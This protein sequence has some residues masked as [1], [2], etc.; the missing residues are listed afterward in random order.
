[1]SAAPIVRYLAELV[2]RKAKHPDREKAQRWL[3][4]QDEMI[5]RERAVAQKKAGRL[6]SPPKAGS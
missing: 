5:A 3:A 6:T 4:L 1:M 2:A